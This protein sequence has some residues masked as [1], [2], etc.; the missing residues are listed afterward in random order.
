M[1][2]LILGGSI[3][4]IF[5]VMMQMPEFPQW[6]GVTLLLIVFIPSFFGVRIFLRSAA[7]EEKN[8]DDKIR[9]EDAHG[10]LDRKFADMKPTNHTL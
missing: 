8:K 7:L 6:L 9:A 1:V 2:L 10:A 3:G 4:C 5:L